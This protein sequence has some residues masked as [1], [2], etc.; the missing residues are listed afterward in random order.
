MRVITQSDTFFSQTQIPDLI[1]ID[2]FWFEKPPGKNSNDTFAQMFCIISD[3][4]GQSDY[5]RYL[6]AGKE[7]QLTAGIASVTDDVFF[8]GQKFKFTLS[9]A[10]GADESFGDNTGLF[11]RGDTVQIKWCNIPVSYTHLRAHETV[12]DIVCRLLLEKQK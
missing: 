7:E 3:L 11:K 8:D 4:Q 10:Q 12:L 6:T 2:S 9:K 5:Y 1:P